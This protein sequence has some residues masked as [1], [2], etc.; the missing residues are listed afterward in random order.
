LAALAGCL[1]A[2]VAFAGPAAAKRPHAN[3]Q[4][5]W[6]TYP[7]EQSP[8]PTSAPQ[9][10][11]RRVRP[12][13]ASDEI[14]PRP[15]A[16]V[17]AVAVGVLV[18]AGGLVVLRLWRRRP[19]PAL[20]A[21]LTTPRAADAPPPR[22][23]QQSGHVPSA[24]ETCWIVCWRGN[25]RAVFYAIAQASDGRQ[26][27]IGESPPFGAT[28][29]TPLVLDAAAFEALQSL[30]TRLSEGGWEVAAPV[31]ARGDVWHAHEFRRKNVAAELRR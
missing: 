16:V 22:A 11:P 20:R 2:A 18:A 28:S 10:R 13:E 23:P 21:P 31:G 27:C 15:V 8:A 19:P 3:P 12:A 1:L 4:G 6:R 9:R 29:N 26:Q 25:R 24:A 7:L 5:L 30:A 17:G 14:S